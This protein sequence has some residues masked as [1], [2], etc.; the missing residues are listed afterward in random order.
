MSP[1]AKYYPRN[2][3]NVSK[4]IAFLPTVKD[5]IVEL[6]DISL[7]AGLFYFSMYGWCFIYYDISLQYRYCLKD[8][9]YEERLRVL[10]LPTLA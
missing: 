1:W 5:I 7:N 2:S 9:T 6:N 8:L 3:L 4:G 10:K